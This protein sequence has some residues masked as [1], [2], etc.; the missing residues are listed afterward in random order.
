[1]A[2]RNL[3]RVRDLLLR[4]VEYQLKP[5]FVLDETG[6][7]QLLPIPDL[8]LAEFEV[9]KK[10]RIKE[11]TITK[12]EFPEES[13]VVAIKRKDNFIIPKDT[14]KLVVGDKVV[15]ILKKESE[16]RIAEMFKEK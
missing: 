7:P 10:S 9:T 15:I 6:Q 5:R 13:S 2:R 16:R 12:I 8:S 4:S 11:K 1:M 3:N 14:E